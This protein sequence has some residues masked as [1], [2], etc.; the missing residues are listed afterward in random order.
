M[1]QPVTV[2]QKPT[3][4]DDVIRFEINRSLTGMEALRYTAGQEIE[5]HRPPDEVARLLL[6]HPGV[7]SVHVYSNVITVDLGAGVPAGD[8]KDEIGG[9]FTYYREGVMPE[10]PVSEDAG[11]E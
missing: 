9:L 8:L 3:S 2:V 4:R 6:A 11:S 5:G 10:V 7:E 1:G